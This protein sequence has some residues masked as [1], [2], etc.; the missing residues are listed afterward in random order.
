MIYI[1][2][3]CLQPTVRL[4][5]AC[6]GQCMSGYSLKPQAFSSQNSVAG[7]LYGREC[8][9]HRTRGVCGDWE[10]KGGYLVSCTH[11]TEMCLLYLTQLH[12]I[13]EVWVLPQSTFTSPRSRS[14]HLAGSGIWTSNLLVT[15]PTLLTARLPATLDSLCVCWVH[16]FQHHK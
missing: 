7:S 15:G 14:F 12:W 1:A 16:C 9:L 13:R 4:M 6:L 3:T 5:Y 8:L 11:S 2:L 10:R